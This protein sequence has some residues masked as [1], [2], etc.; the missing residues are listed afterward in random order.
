[1]EVRAYRDGPEVPMCI[2]VGCSR[3][4]D[5]RVKDFTVT[6]E[7]WP[8]RCSLHQRCALEEMGPLTNTPVDRILHCAMF[9]SFPQFC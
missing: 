3:L 1:M 8:D 9:R 2:G 6:S 4:M 7:R 5:Y